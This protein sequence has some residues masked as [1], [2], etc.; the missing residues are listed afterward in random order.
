M[1]VGQELYDD[2][3]SFGVLTGTIGLYFGIVLGVILIIVGIVFLVKKNDFMKVSATMIT[4][5]CPESTAPWKCSV[6]VQYYVFGIKYTIQMTE[7]AFGT[8][9]KVGDTKDIYVDKN[10]PGGDNFKMD[11]PGVSKYLG[12]G[13]LI[14]GIVVILTAWLLYYIVRHSKFAASAVG[15]GEGASIIKSAVTGDNN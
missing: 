4:K 9:A 2:S 1:G 13:L 14:G 11:F 8:D 3:A 12:L 6:T 10:D 7:D 5:D 15:I